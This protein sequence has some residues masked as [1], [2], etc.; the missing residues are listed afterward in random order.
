MT[1][2]MSPVAMLENIGVVQKRLS[3]AAKKQLKA[4][5]MYGCNL[6]RIVR[7]REILCKMGASMYGLGCGGGPANGSVAVRMNGREKVN[8]WVAIRSPG[9]NSVLGFL[10]APY[11]GFY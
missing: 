10:P 11:M 8:W 1:C 5:R 2:V 9:C 4:G 6:F 7:I 3:E